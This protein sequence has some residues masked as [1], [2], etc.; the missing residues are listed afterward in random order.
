MEAA[1]GHSHLNGPLAGLHVD[2]VAVTG[3]FLGQGCKA[4]CEIALELCS[5]ATIEAAEPVE[6]KGELERGARCWRHRAA[7]RQDEAVA[8]LYGVRGGGNHGA[9]AVQQADGSGFR[10]P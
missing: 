1:R 5:Q 8:V 6:G 3:N 4:V 7:P 10:R 9:A 2:T